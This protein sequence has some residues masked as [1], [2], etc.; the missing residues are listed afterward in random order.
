MAAADNHRVVT[1]SLYPVFHRIA[2]PL[3]PA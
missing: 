1:A 3:L 2:C